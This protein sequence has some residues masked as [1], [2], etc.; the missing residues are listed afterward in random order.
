[1]R[2]VIF[3]DG[4]WNK[5]DATDKGTNVVKLCEATVNDRNQGQVTAYDSGVGS[6]WYNRIRGG[7]FGMGISENIKDSY[8]AIVKEWKSH[9]D[10][11]FLFGFSRGAYT[12]R[13]LAGL[14]GFVGIVREEDAI[15][16]AYDF[17]RDLKKI[18]PKTEKDRK[19]LDPRRKAEFDRFR[20]AH[21][22]DL[23]QR[24]RIKMIGVWDTVG[25]L[26]IPQSWLN[27]HLNPFPHEFHDTSLG[28]GVENAY[29]AVSIDEKRKAFQPTLWDPDPRVRQVCFAGVHSDVGGGYEDHPEL[30]YI[31]L[32]WMADH[33][34]RHGLQLDRTRLPKLKGKEHLGEQHESWTSAW[35]VV[36]RHDREWADPTCLHRSV[37]K[38]F[39]A[40]TGTFKP[41]PYAP[42]KVTPLERFG[43]DPE[44]DE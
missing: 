39:D 26:G 21:V 24:V 11:I 13:S 38:R 9:D 10:E 5:M 7:A 17:Y 1:M 34:E 20:Q 15:D 32:I 40:P 16:Q 29:H 19:K 37:R 4:T 28:A 27:E 44:K 6:R 31:T 30:G 35:R 18:A 42:V 8:R 22:H 36:R 23:D 12:V 41:H 33:A 43:W 25:A 3:A 2:I 14:I